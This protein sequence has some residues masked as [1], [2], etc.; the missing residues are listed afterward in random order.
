ML[1]IR[2]IARSAPR[3]VTRFSAATLRQTARPSAFIKASS[4]GLQRASNFSS[5][6]FRKAP[7]TDGELISKLESELQ[8]EDEVKQNEQLPASVKDFIDNSPFKLHDVP[9]KE[10]VTLTREFNDEK[11]TITFSIADLANYDPEFE[12]DRALE[13]EDY[14]PSV[15]N[16]NRQA[17]VQSTGGARSAPAEEEMEEEEEADE[18]APPCRLSIVVEKPGKTPGALNI[19][20]TAQDGDIVVDNMYYFEDGKLAHT[21]TADVAHAR[22]AVYPGPPFGSLDEDLQVLMERYLE[23]RGISQALAVFAPDYI[24]VKEQREYVR[25]LNNV[26]GF[27]KA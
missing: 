11:I 18:P 2:S 12:Q 24:D 9:G 17:G 27:V 6:A 15:Q 25:W 13:D 5:S 16:S 8:F 23:E 3:T 4:C 20:A 10:E 14:D 19:D 21:G 1:S 22:G 26:K 7:E